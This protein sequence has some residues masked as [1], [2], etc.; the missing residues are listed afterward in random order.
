MKILIIHNTYQLKGGEDVVF[1]AESELLAQEGHE[2]ETV[3]FDNKE[4]RSLKDRL[5]IGIKSIYNWQSATLIEDKI[6]YFKPDILH[7]HN[8]F[9]LLSPSVFFVASK[10]NIPVVMTLHNFRLL[11]PSAILYFDHRIYEKSVHKI[12][13]M[14]AILN[15]VYRN[16]ILETAAVSLVTGVHKLIGTWRNKVDRYIVL[17]EFAKKKFLNSSLQVTADQL[18][19]KANFVEDLGLDFVEREMYFLF[20]GRLSHEKGIPT[21]FEAA[22][23]GGFKLKVIGDGPMRELV[24]EYASKYPNIEYLGF[25]DKAFI[26]DQMRRC[27]ALVFPSACFEGCPMTILEAYS[28]GSIVL[29]ANIGA[30][31]EIVQHQTNGLLFESGNAEDLKKQVD[32][33]SQNEKEMNIMLGNAR[34]S[35]E[36]KYHPHVNYEILMDIYNE[37][38]EAKK[39]T[40]SSVMVS[41]S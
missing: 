2:V 27:R 18:S 41:E 30:I 29:A 11:C 24:E 28:V 22:K 19:V 5:I 12:F 34:L 32:W 13:P 1:R 23:L 9:P 33:L 6:N 25:Q 38:I 15:G 20:V 17:S 40:L 31:G 8:F 35:Y 36:R 16:S 10:L 14:H 7:I 3:I 21:L 26:I 4:I 39:S 37:L